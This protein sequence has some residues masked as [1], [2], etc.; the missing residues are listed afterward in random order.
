MR[1]VATVFP[2][3]GGCYVVKSSYGKLALIHVEFFVQVKVHHD[4]DIVKSKS[5]NTDN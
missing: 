2:R 5:N 1:I 3:G 4:V